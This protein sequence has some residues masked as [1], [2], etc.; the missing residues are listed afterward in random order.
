MKHILEHYF[1]NYRK[2]KKIKHTISKPLQKAIKK[3]TD[4]VE[5]INN[6]FMNRIATYIERIKDNYTDDKILDTYSCFFIIV[7]KMYNRNMSLDKLEKFVRNQD[8]YINYYNW[9]S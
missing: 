6:E 7:N 2:F 5:K 4:K 1:S 8:R 3:T 9:D